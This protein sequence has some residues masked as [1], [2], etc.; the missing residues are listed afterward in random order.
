MP[1]LNVYIKSSLTRTGLI[2]LFLILSF[3]TQ[4][5][6]GP[7]L[8]QLSKSLNSTWNTLLKITNCDLKSPQDS[9][10]IQKYHGETIVV[11]L[12]GQSVNA[13]ILFES[14]TTP[15]ISGSV[16]TQQ[17][18]FL[19]GPINS[20]GYKVIQEQISHRSDHKRQIMN[21]GLKVV[22]HSVTDE[23]ISPQGIELNKG[24]RWLD[25]KNGPW[26]YHWSSLAEVHEVLKELE[27]YL[28]SNYGK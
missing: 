15:D 9:L 12:F 7:S 11:K 24:Q 27:Q 8:N 3:T 14:F 21:N 4:A 22:A 13:L 16:I 18:G 20:F 25:N 2:V 10:C 28:N 23:N 19:I 6:S 5:S 1:R 26:I 17:S